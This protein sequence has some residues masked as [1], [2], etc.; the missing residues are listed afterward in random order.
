MARQS[1][2]WIWLAVVMLSPLW[3][4]CKDDPDDKDANKEHETTIRCDTS[5]DCPSGY[6]CLLFRHE[7]I[8]LANER[9]CLSDKDCTDIQICVRYAPAKSENDATSTFCTFTCDQNG[10]DE[11]HDKGAL[12]KCSEDTNEHDYNEHSQS[13]CGRI[14][15]TCGNGRLDAGELCDRDESGQF[16]FS[17]DAPSCQLWEPKG[18]FKPGGMPGCA[19]TCIGYTKGSGKTKCVYASDPNNVNGFDT[20]L[21]SLYID[22]DTYMAYATVN[23]AT[24]R[25][26]DL[27]NVEGYLLCGPAGNLN[28]KILT[29]EDKLPAAST[30][31]ESCLDE[32]CTSRI[33][34][35][36]RDLSTVTSAIDKEE[37][38]CVVYLKLSSNKLG[39][40]C[41]LTYKDNDPD[42]IPPNGTMPSA[43]ANDPNAC[44]TI[45][46]TEDDFDI[47]EAFLANI[48]C[49]LSQYPFVSY[50][51]PTSGTGPHTDDALLL[52]SW[53]VFPSFKT[54]AGY[55]IKA[56]AG[57]D[58][59]KAGI[60]AETGTCTEDSICKDAILSLVVVGN[61]GFQKS[62]VTQTAGTQGLFE[63]LQLGGSKNDWATEKPVEPYAAT[64]LSVAVSDL[65]KFRARRLSFKGT[66]EKGQLL[67]T[68]FD[69]TDEHLLAEDVY[70]PSR[71]ERC[72][73]A[74]TDEDKQALGCPD[75]NNEGIL[76]FTVP[77]EAQ[78]SEFRIYV[79]AIG[80]DNLNLN[81][82]Q[83][84][85][86][87]NVIY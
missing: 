4:G 82:L 33:L 81:W 67:V 76:Q 75:E 20:C 39:V 74:G 24:T 23:Y 45:A 17:T 10:T 6:G 32:D 70:L 71:D 44:V 27:D 9:Q 14:P 54:D 18:T 13:F 79:Y 7:C 36:T 3:L 28:M 37:G 22:Q 56:Q 16:V 87:S 72:D 52:A 84:W 42:N 55:P 64:H 49:V 63:T 50:I 77:D 59:L 60:P 80:N 26:S 11:C 53:D 62:S 69:G 41:D 85:G 2:K 51:P 78:I 1:N 8:D 86:I 25:A 12:R 34:Y 46:G 48:H 61:T 19:S 40:V 83:V 29:D 35:I 15:S 47:Y 57:L 73:E 68:Y 43:A 5:D 58:L 21:A 30:D 38:Q 31:I 65:D 66:L